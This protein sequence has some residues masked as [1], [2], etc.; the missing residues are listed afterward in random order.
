MLV[1]GDTNVVNKVTF[2]NV[3]LKS[4]A[5]FFLV[6]LLYSADFYTFIVSN[7]YLVLVV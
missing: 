3:W 1:K 2:K 5:T 7:K 6:I 4:W